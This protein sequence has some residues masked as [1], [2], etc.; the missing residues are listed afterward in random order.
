MDFSKLFQTLTGEKDEKKPQQNHNYFNDLPRNLSDMEKEAYY[1]MSVQKTDAELV[2]HAP[3]GVACDSA[4]VSNAASDN[5]YNNIPGSAPDIIF[6]HFASQGFIGY[7]ACALLKQNWMISNACTVPAEDAIRPGY[8][9]NVETN[10]QAIK[11]E[12]L[13]RLQAESYSKYHIDEICRQAVVNMRTFGIGL[14]F[15]VFSNDYDYEVPFNIDSVRKHSYK[16]WTVVDP[17]WFA[18]ILD[19]SAA[20]DPSAPNFYKPTWYQMP[21]GKL[22]HHSHCVVLINSEVPDLLKPTYFYG[23]IPLTQ[24]IYQRVYAAE[25]VA[26]EAPLLALT[27][28]LLVVDANL[29]NF[30]ANQRDAEK[31]LQSI[32]WLRDNFGVAVKRPGDQIQQIDT[33]LSDFDAL[34][35]TQYQ[36]VASVAQMPATKLLKTTPK[37]FNSTGEFELKDYIQLLQ[38][39]QTNR[40]K[41]IIERH[42]QLWLKSEYGKSAEISITFKPIDMPTDA[43]KSAINQAMASTLATLA[44]SG[45]ISPEEARER[46]KRDELSGFPTIDTESVPEDDDEEMQQMFQNAMSMAN[47]KKSENTPDEKDEEE[48]AER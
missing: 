9:V 17:Y 47:K 23:G 21:N 29:E 15:P 7:N 12:V 19:E 2:A 44:Q 40:M 34:I 32:S 5:V 42:N 39:I 30:V 48:P 38:S 22:I 1:R 10:A 11:E 13:D 27:K 18:P 37:G 46:L 16:G 24:M 4:D 14:A 36:L 3:D 35:M 45:I 43:D 6:T 31:T 41:P 8:E 20:T 33:S 26:N 25:K 28:R